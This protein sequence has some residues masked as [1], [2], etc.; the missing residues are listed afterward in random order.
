MA[1]N[2]K[3]AGM[4]QQ[5]FMD[6][7]QGKN[8]TNTSSSPAKVATSETTAQP[9]SN[10]P[11]D[12]FTKPGSPSNTPVYARGLGASTK[13][14]ISNS[15]KNV[16]HVCSIPDVV[17]LAIAKAGWFGAQIVILL[18]K[19]WNAILKFFGVNPS[20]SAFIDYF[21][22]IAMWIKSL[23]DWLKDI[24]K[25]LVELLQF[26]KIVRDIVAFIMSLPSILLAYFK[27]CLKVALA[28]L[29]QGYL[30]AIAAESIDIDKDAMNVLDDV[31]KTIDE[32][33][34]AYNEVS[35][36]V[37]GLVSTAGQTITMAGELAT[38][39]TNIETL[40]T[41]GDPAAGQAQLQLMMADAGYADKDSAPSA[42]L[43]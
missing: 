8:V 38:S 29:K 6:M 31:K 40:V 4:T 23:T 11:D 28:A 10:S 33:Q 39:V 32:V 34:T 15:N 22:K 3:F 21:K 35:K 37:N 30:D 42:A 26:I 17:K 18:R 19:A 9:T 7:L 43:A 5:D 12:S 14:G 25:Y 16:A 36:S 41:S 2:S 1:D 27:D 20:S 13:S 24:N